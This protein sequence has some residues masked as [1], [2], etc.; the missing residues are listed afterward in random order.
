MRRR[1]SNA[2]K[3]PLKPKLCPTWYVDSTVL[4]M[5]LFPLFG[6]R[7]LADT[8]FELGRDGQR[9]CLPRFQKHQEFLERYSRR[10]WWGRR[11]CRRGRQ[12]QRRDLAIAEELY[13]FWHQLTT[14]RNH[15]STGFYNRGRISLALDAA[16]Q[17]EKLILHTFLRAR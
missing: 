9:T 12:K 17:N 5:A 8:A 6:A 4:S 10:K 16:G 1:C 2:R 3:L 7:R 11:Q 14:C 15:A 13:Q